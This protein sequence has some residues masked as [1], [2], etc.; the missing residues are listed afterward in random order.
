VPSPVLRG[1]AGIRLLHSRGAATGLTV[2]CGEG[3]GAGAPRGDRTAPLS[4]RHDPCDLE[5]ERDD[6]RCHSEA[7]ACCSGGGL[8]DEVEALPEQSCPGRACDWRVSADILRVRT[9]LWRESTS[10]ARG[11][12]L[13]S[14]DGGAARSALWWS[15]NREKR[16]DAE[17]HSNGDTCDGCRCCRPL[18]NCSRSCR[19]RRKRNRKGEQQSA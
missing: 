10:P 11:R 4:P 16:Q 12:K 15:K 13:Q 2:R 19:Y 8:L 17:H 9:N 7:L 1:G 3:P 5:G 18:R 14:G 6:A